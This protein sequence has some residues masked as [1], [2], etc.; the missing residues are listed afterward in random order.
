MTLAKALGGG[1]PIGA[2]VT[3]PELAE[4]LE[5]GDHGSTFAGGPVAAAAAHAVL[6]VVDDPDLLARVDELGVRL[7]EG[8]AAVPRVREVRGR[9]LMAGVDVDA[10]APALVRRGL[11]EQR[12]VLN[13]TGPATLRFLPPLNIAEDDLDEAL[14]R[15]NELLSTT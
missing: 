10:D 3:T 11:A 13:A 2:L 6:D 7:R 15:V 8:L 4:V 14:R 12:I 5:P 9:G 1:L